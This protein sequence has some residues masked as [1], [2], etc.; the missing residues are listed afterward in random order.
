MKEMKLT[1]PFINKCPDIDELF[2][3]DN[4]HGVIN[5]I[6][7]LCNRIKVMASKYADRYDE[8]LFK[9][10]ALEL[11][12]E[13]MIKTAPEDNRIGIYDYMPISELGIDD[14][15]V[16]GKGIGEDGFPATVQVKYRA[17]DY[18]LTGNADH[19][20]NFVSYS[21][22]KFGVPID[23]STNM[24]IVTT[25]LKVDERTRENML[26]GKVR[27]L[28][29]EDLRRMYDNRP[30]WWKRFYE[31]VR[32]SR[33]V[34]SKTRN[35]L[36]LRLHQEE[37]VDAILKDLNCK[38]KIILP[39]GTGK[40]LIEAEIVRLHIDMLIKKGIDAPVIKVNSSRILLCFQLFEDV[41]NRLVDFGI[42]A[43]Y[44]NF[45]SGNKDD[46]DYAE[47]MRREGWA[48]RQ[49]IS[50]TKSSEVKKIYHQ[51]QIDNIPLVVFS[52]YHSAENFA[53]SEIVPHLTIHD[54]AHNLVS[55][56]FHKA[57]LLPTGGNLFFTATEK[58]TDSDSDKGMN[59]KDVFDEMIYTKSAREMIDAGEMVPPYVHVIR[60]SNG[61][62][63]DTD[64]EKM[65]ES[66][67]E[68]FEFHERKIKSISFDAEQIGAKVLVVCRG[69][70]DLLQ[71]LKTDVV[72]KFKMLRPDIHLFA[73]SSDYGIC[74]DGEFFKPPVTNMKKHE[75]LKK[76]K[77]LGANEKALIFHVDMIGEG[78]DVPG[79]TGVMP[80]RNCEESK[81][82]QNVGRSSRLH[83]G[84]RKRFYNGEIDPSDK[85]K[86]IKPCSWVIIPSYMI[87]SEGLEGRFRTI[88]NR[89]RNEFGYI[90]QQ[91][92]VIDNVEGL[93]DDPAIDKVNEPNKKK[94]QAKSGVDA[95]N[96]EFEKISAI[97][98]MIRDEMV[99]AK[100]KSILESILMKKNVDN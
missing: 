26:Y 38:G 34:A 49:I 96:H 68:G 93:D 27:V 54:E 61:R 85:S 22:N 2:L 16:D 3:A 83:S 40:T 48:Y 56:E 17:G 92:T 29:R 52:T 76:M 9:G 30:E 28:A 81:L 95:L 11:F 90:P 97:E 10:D 47:M 58:V 98:M 74:N 66:V 69:Q 6:N 18:V 71:M 100:K 19:L 24:L 21:Q 35:P 33:I 37:A 4:E 36:P 59:N 84:D 79:I 53:K 46:D 5:S 42:Q 57:A 75:L 23:N 13:Y 14:F 50:T 72:E 82:I 73:L 45:N 12:A 25:G 32:D 67:I 87:D 31:S 89:L 80:F 77:S 63:V 91:H 78:I 65:F 86:W 62:K 20:T 15:G 94:K 44:V 43:R 1:H 51:C 99:F 55:N 8:S 39:T 70:E 41:L 64:Y 88:I 7:M 60:S